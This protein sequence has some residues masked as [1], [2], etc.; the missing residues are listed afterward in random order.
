MKPIIGKLLPLRNYDGKTIDEKIKREERKDFITQVII[1]QASYAP[2]NLNLSR[3]NFRDNELIC[4]LN[5]VF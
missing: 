4:C 2:Y 3:T 5:Y 1:S